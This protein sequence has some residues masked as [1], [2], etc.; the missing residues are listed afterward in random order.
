MDIKLTN[1][2]KC[3]AEFDDLN[4]VFHPNFSKQYKKAISANK[5][6]FYNYKGIFTNMYDAGNRNGNFIE[7]FKNS[8]NNSNKA[9]DIKIRNQ[10]IDNNHIKNSL[11]IN[12]RKIRHASLVNG[13]DLN[14]NQ[15]EKN[16]LN[17]NKSNKLPLSLKKIQLKIVL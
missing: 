17:N 2:K 1:R 4:H 10:D 6:I 11:I 13:S 7:L 14:L 8:N 9:D 5:N 3:I 16:E 12:S 15:N